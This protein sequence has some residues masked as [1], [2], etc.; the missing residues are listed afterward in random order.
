LQ[1]EGQWQ[2][3]GLAHLTPFH[4]RPI[5]WGWTP[6]DGG[7]RLPWLHDHL[8]TLAFVSRLLITQSNYIPWKG[9]FDAINLVDEFILYDDVQYTR[10]DWRNRNLIK[11]AQGLHWLTIP[12]EVKGKYLQ[13]IQ[14]TKVSDRRWAAEHWKTIEHHYAKAP[15][16][17]DYQEPFEELY[18]SLT[19]EYLSE[20]NFAFL[21]LICEL[22]GITT[23]MKWSSAFQLPADRTER[24]VELCVREGATE[25]YSG[26]AAK[27]YLDEDA[28]RARNI[29]VRY[30]DYSGYPEY[31][32]LHGEFVH[33]VSIIDLLFNEGEHAKRFLKSFPSA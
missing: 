17:K 28:F 33:G 7:L 30:L 16:F 2:E 26:P 19:T 23:T 6:A 22:L 27:A 20:I 29:A 11:T 21:R 32:Q 8:L 25:Y 31:R 1:Y 15:H 18:A 3:F 14:D 24:L 10:R 12:V 13:K 4:G 9:Y 5:I